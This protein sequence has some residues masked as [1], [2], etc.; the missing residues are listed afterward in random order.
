[1]KFVKLLRSLWNHLKV[2]KIVIAHH[3]T[4][5]SITLKGTEG[6]KIPVTGHR[7]PKI[8]VI[9]HTGSKNTIYWAQGVQKYQLFGTRSPKIPFTREQWGPKIPGAQ[10]VQKYHLQGQRG[11]KIP[12]TGHRG[13][14]KKVKRNK[15]VENNC[16]KRSQL[17]IKIYM[18]ELETI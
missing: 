9:W 11:P 3:Y 7:G 4:S 5:R 16:K 17:N 6:P 1:M 14:K 12:V 13:S 15:A 10:G 18:I 2:Q 8:P